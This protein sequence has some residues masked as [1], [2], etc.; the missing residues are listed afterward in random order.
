MAYTV[1]QSIAWAGS[2]MTSYIPLTSQTGSE[3]AITIANMVV[4]FIQN[5]PFTWPTNR[6]EDTSL[7]T[8]AGTQ[9]YVLSI[10]DF[11][12]L[13]TVTLTNAANKSWA[14]PRIYNSS[15]LGISSEQSSR[16]EACC[17]KLVTPGT[18]IALRFLSAPDAVYTG[19]STYQKVPVLFTA[20]SQDWFGQCNIPIYYMDIFNNLFL[21]ECFQVNGD[22]Q[23]AGLYRRR[24]MA[25]LISKAEGLTEMQKNV[26]LAQAMYSDLQSIA[27]TLRTQTA[28][29]AR[30]I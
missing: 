22:A 28:Q 14:V 29:Q 25:A 4:S 24:G 8:V 18:S 20:T 6:K 19:T 26:M 16:P 17:V 3:P 23:E 9:D 5:P 15:V 21:A 1:N 27:A 7:T 12:F 2:M 13:E 10:T 11:G 30:T